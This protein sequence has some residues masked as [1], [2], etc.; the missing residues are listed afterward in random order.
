MS[1][2]QLKEDEVIKL[3]DPE[4]EP[5]LCGLNA[6][7][8]FEHR[9]KECL[10]EVLTVID[11]TLPEERQNKA[12][13]DVIKKIVHRMLSQAQRY[14]SDMDSKEGASWGSSINI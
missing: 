10:G 9:A 3:S 11:A 12:M 4:K 14:C 8:D 13:K 7:T 5:H 6:Y 1:K 2:H